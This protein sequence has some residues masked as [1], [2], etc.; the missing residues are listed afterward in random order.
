MADFF[1]TLEIRLK[2]QTESF[3]SVVIVVFNID[4]KKN[5]MKK[6]FPSHHNMCAKSKTTCVCVLR[7]FK[8]V[9]DDAIKAYFAS[10]RKT[11]SFFNL[12][13]SK[14]EFPSLFCDD[15]A[16]AP[17]PFYLLSLCRSVSFS[18]LFSKALVCVYLDS[19]RQRAMT[20]LNVSH[21]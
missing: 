21:K 11:F 10:K 1:L 16:N 3:S 4:S 17:L 2:R 12:P 7:E 14:C 8:E 13:S 15:Y 9:G 19:L 20:M 5:T 18:S 6:K